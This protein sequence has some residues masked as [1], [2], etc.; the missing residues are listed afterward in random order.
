VPGAVKKVIVGDTSPHDAGGAKAQGFT[1]MRMYLKDSEARQGHLLFPQ[2]PG[3]SKQA[4]APPG[5]GPPA[6]RGDG[7]RRAIPG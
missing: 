6:L 4:R 5:E 7:G 2:Q 1:D 3:W